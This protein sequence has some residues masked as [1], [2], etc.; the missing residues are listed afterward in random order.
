MSAIIS[1]GQ[2]L[3]LRVIAEGVETQEQLGFL[4]TQRCG[5][6]RDGFYFSRPVAADQFAEI[7]KFASGST[8]PPWFTTST[9]RGDMNAN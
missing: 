7:V 3:Q 8:V 2:S 6:G 4:Q 5:R 9:P 1:M